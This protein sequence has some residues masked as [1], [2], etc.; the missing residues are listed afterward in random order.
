VVFRPSDKNAVAVMRVVHEFED[1]AGLLPSVEA[2]QEI[3]PA[4]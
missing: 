4:S 1:L 3:G 2:H